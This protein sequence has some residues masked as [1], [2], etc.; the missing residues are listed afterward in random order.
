MNG[1]EK[2]RQSDGGDEE[3]GVIDRRGEQKPKQW[4][5]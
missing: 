2:E 1:Y 4:G 5:T 3:D